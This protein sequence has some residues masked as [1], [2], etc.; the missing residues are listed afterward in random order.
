MHA[1]RTSEMKH[2]TRTP[3]C[4]GGNLRVLS[5]CNA[6]AQPWLAAPLPQVVGGARREI[7]EHMHAA[8]GGK[9]R[10]DQMRADKPKP[11]GDED[12]A[13]GQTVGRNKTIGQGII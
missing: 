10:I 5:R 2:A 4:R 8:P 1:D 12:L 3:T 9:Q 11:T 6:D 13:Y 7:I